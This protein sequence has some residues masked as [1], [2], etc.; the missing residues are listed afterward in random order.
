MLMNK[1]SHRKKELE[2]DGS[3]HLKTNHNIRVVNLQ[4]VRMFS[5]CLVKFVMKMKT[6]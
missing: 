2:N 1:K 6:R 5:V 3:N 4:L